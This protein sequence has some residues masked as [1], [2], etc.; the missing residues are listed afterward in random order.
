MSFL[1]VKYP[2]R[3]KNVYIQNFIMYSLGVLTPNLKK[4]SQRVDD[5]LEISG[6]NNSRSRSNKLY[7]PGGIEGVT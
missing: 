2:Q 5:I 7:L 4:K 3:L 6:S 1:L